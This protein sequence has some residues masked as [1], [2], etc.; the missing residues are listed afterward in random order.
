MS[1]RFAEL[2]A[3]SASQTRQAEVNAQTLLAEKR[4]KEEQKRKEKEEREKKER[5]QQARLVKLRLDE[6]KRERE[7]RDKAEEEKRKKE[8]LL[9]KKEA[10]QRDALLYG[11]KAG[12][13]SNWGNKGPRKARDGSDDE[14]D[15][16]ATALTREEKRQR[17]AQAELSRSFSNK[18]TT[19][20]GG[21]SKA[22]KAFRGATIIS[23]S[24][25]PLDLSSPA[26]SHLSVKERLAAMP[27]V[28]TKLNTVKRDTRTIDEIVRDRQKAREAKVLDGDE[29]RGFNDWFGKSKKNDSPTPKKS[30]SAE[31]SV[32]PPPSRA[33]TPGLPPPKPRAT[34]LDAPSP[35]KAPPSRPAQ[36]RTTIRKIIPAK[37]TYDKDSKFPMVFS[38][39]GPSKPAQ[40]S[41]KAPANVQRSAPSMSSRSLNSQPSSSA[42][43]KRPRSP[44][45]S[46]SPPPAPKRRSSSARND[47]SSEI[48]KLFGKDRDRYVNNDVYSD[49]DDD[50]EADAD[51]LRRE[52]LRRYM[53]RLY[54]YF[55]I[56]Y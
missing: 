12:S 21:N 9:A 41:S 14:M 32:S 38:T 52:E 25:N 15:T 54:S 16:G 34:S 23:S 24:T 26:N 18:R 5:E 11:P 20:G 1:A 7:R 29:A 30:I 46:D 55:V 40:G 39:R 27:M 47:Y 6:E 35:A 3:L 43:K 36:P 51:A 28:L 53:P 8:Q 48:W 50:M 10:E 13:K 4:R 19:H 49:E 22:N 17:K 45:L 44:S 31:S 42:G 2:M 56:T 33:Q 37:P